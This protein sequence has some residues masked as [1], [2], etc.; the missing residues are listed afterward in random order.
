[1]RVSGKKKFVSTIP[2]IKRIL[3]GNKTST[4]LFLNKYIKRLIRY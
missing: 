1:M 4:Y 2:A 3:N